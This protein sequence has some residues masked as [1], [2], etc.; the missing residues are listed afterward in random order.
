NGGPL[1]D[2]VAMLLLTGDNTAPLVASASDLLQRQPATGSRADSPVVVGATTA[3]T[4]DISA[5]TPVDA[6]VV[7]ADVTTTPFT[8]TVPI[9]TTSNAPA[10]G[11]PAAGSPAAETAAITPTPGSHA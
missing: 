7:N 10:S 8:T 4:R 9:T 1:A 11:S 6:T 2:D 3:T 5:M